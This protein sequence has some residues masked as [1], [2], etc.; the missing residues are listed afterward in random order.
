MAAMLGSTGG[1]GG[2]AERPAETQAVSER[3]IPASSVRRVRDNDN[4][5]LLSVQW[6]PALSRSTFMAKV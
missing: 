3:G 6:N 1:F 5:V 2:R 4:L